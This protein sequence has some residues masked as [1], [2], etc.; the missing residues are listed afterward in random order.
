MNDGWCLLLSLIFGSVL[1][2][3]IV[4]KGFPIF[5]IRNESVGG[6]ND[7]L[8]G[9]SDDEH[10]GQRKFDGTYLFHLID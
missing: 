7:D 5:C 2:R 10:D 1:D 9:L 4:A 6:F 8:R 3:L